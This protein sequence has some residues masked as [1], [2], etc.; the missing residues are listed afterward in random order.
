[1]IQIFYNLSIETFATPITNHHQYHCNNFATTT[2][3][4]AIPTSK[5]STTTTPSLVWTTTAS[6]LKNFQQLSFFPLVKLVEELGSTGGGGDG[7]DPAGD[8]GSRKRNEAILALAEAGRSLESLPKDLA[9]EAGRVLG[10][11]ASRYLEL[12]KSPVFRRLLQFGGF[13]ERLLAD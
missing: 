3:C 6:R 5:L 11:I 12:E 2:R 10:S 7:N 8:A 1:M 4:I 13:K 9:A